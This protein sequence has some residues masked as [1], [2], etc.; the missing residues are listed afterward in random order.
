MLPL[1]FPLLYKHRLFWLLYF[2]LNHKYT[3]WFCFVLYYLLVLIGLN[4][5]NSIFVLV[6]LLPK[7]F[8]YFHL[9]HRYILFFD[10]PHF[11]HSLLR[12]WF[13]LLHLY[14]GIHILFDTFYYLS[15]LLCLVI[16]KVYHNLYVFLHP[17]LV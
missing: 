11:L 12:L 1:Y 10:Y 6:V 8:G 17:Y 3:L 14:H 5:H 7:W 9:H 4:H 2:H 16:S 15:L 13:C